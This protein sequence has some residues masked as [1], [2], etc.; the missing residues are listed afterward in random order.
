MTGM[1]KENQM[2]GSVILE[3]GGGVLMAIQRKSM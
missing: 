3:Q 2:V 1:V